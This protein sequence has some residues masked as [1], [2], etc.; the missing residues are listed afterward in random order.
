[1]RASLIA[2]SLFAFAVVTTARAEAGMFCMTRDDFNQA[3]GQLEAFAKDP[4]NL[5][6]PS[7]LICLRAGFAPPSDQ[8]T[9]PKNFS[10]RVEKACTKILERER[11]NDACVELA[12]RMAKTELGGVT[13]LE[14]ALG[15]KLDVWNWDG[16][17]S[18]LWVL[19]TIGDAR[20]AQKLVDT[21]T[22]NLPVAAKR[23]KRGWSLQAWAGWRTEAAEA[24]GKV[25]VAEHAAFLREQAGATKD[26]YVKKACLAAAAAIDK[27]ATP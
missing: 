16:W 10:A 8:V 15:W 20:A 4:R 27:R 3:A 6:D 22:A 9:V 7:A 21:W 11:D 24:I 26:R 14:A 5:F 13:L 2:A 23:E 12:V 18:R 19:G 25:G 17:Q 1:M